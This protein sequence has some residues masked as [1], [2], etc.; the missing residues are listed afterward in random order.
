MKGS[1]V[2][3]MTTENQELIQWAKK[4]NWIW[5]RYGKSKI[6]RAH[7]KCKK[8]AFTRRITD[9]AELD[10]YEHVKWRKR[11]KFIKRREKYDQLKKFLKHREKTSSVQWFPDHELRRDMTRGELRMRKLTRE[12]AAKFAVMIR[13]AGQSSSYVIHI[14]RMLNENRIEEIHSKVK[15]QEKEYGRTQCPNIISLLIVL[16]WLIWK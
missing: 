10:I 7:S 15:W 3:C 14:W 5:I 1:W 4:N 16:T 9:I 6:L 13:G 11:C 12:R 2:V 8:N